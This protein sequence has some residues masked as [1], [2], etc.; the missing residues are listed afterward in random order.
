MRSQV[1]V[2]VAEFPRGSELEGNRQIA[3]FGLTEY[4]HERG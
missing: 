2:A 4:L 1:A 3:A